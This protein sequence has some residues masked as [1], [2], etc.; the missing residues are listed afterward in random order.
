VFFASYMVIFLFAGMG[1]GSTYR[2][3]PSI[4]A[5][6]GR[7]EAEEKGTD[8]K[9]TLLD[10]KRQAAAVIGIVGAVGAFGGFLIQVVLRQASLGV[11]ALIKAAD[12]PAQKV[13][14]AHAHAD[15]SVPALWVFVGA[16]VVFAG[17]TWFF[18]LRR[19]S[20]RTERLRSEASRAATCCAPDARSPTS[21][22]ALWSCP[23]SSATPSRPRRAPRRRP[24]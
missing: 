18:Y 5:A 14:I 6:L 4:F 22:A 17:I 7:R 20:A 11:S 24:P 19:S 23:S 10:H 15:W 21:P 12:T 8:P 3:I 9:E 16:Y 1:N 2:M 13:A